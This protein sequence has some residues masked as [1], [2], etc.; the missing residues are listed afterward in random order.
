MINRRREFQS[1]AW[2]LV[3][4]W[5]LASM[6]QV[7]SDVYSLSNRGLTAAY[8]LGFAG[9]TIGAAGTIRYVRH[10]LGANVHVIALSVAGWGVGALVA[11]V[12]GLFVL[13]G[14]VE[15]RLLGPNHGC[16]P[17]RCNRRCPHASD[18]V[19]VVSG[20]YCARE[21]VGRI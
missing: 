20:N 12:L 14:N 10:R 3:A 18:V 19:T 11:V 7:I 15:R 1:V 2:A 4:G 21:C 17:R 8:V 6:G 13:A 5:V 9:W 16:G